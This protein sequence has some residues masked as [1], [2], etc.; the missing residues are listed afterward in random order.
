M[1]RAENDTSPRGLPQ[2]AEKAQQDFVAQTGGQEPVD[3][4]KSTVNQPAPPTA[5]PEWKPPP[6]EQPQPNVTPEGY[7]LDDVLYGPSNR[8]NEPFGTPA[9]QASVA[10][11]LQAL[12]QTPDVVALLRF[13][14]QKG[15]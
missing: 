10:E 14:Q 7:N 4:L 12:P 6:T 5:Q 15:L 13:A 9:T 3:P 8:P 11:M 2:G 1:P